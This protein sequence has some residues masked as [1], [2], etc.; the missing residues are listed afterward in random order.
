MRYLLGERLYR[1]ALLARPEIRST[2]ILTL[3][4]PMGYINSSTLSWRVKLY[5][6]TYNITIE[7]SLDNGETWRSQLP[8]G[9]IPGLAKP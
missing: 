9:Q 4:I 5:E 3:T 1:E 8:G 6:N 7:T 2:D